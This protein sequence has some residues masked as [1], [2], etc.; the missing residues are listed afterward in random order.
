MRIFKDFSPIVTMLT[1]VVYDLKAFILFYFILN[2]LFSLLFGI[3]GIGNLDE[4]LNPKFSEAFKEDAEKGEQYPGVEYKHI[5]L[6]VGN[7]FSAIRVSVGD[8]ARVEAANYLSDEENY[9]FW[10]YWFIMVVIASIIFLNFII[11]EASASYEKVAG[12]VEQYILKEQA[13]LI[14][15]SEIMTP[16]FLKS[17]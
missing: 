9:M 8:Y 4:N 3:I 13:N 7:L 14:G 12:E 6:L 1:T 10:I 11:A 17:E 5:G 16:S 15:E 2:G